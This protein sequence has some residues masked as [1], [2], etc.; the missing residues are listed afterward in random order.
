M[1]CAKWH[2]HHQPQEVF[3][4]SI[5]HK[6]L[7]P[8]FVYPCTERDTEP[9]NILSVPM[10]YK[11]SSQQGG[12]QSHLR[13]SPSWIGFHGSCSPFQPLSLFGSCSLLAELREGSCHCCPG[14]GV[15]G[16]VMVG[17]LTGVQGGGSECGRK[18]LSNT[19]T[20]E[21][22]VNL[23]TSSTVIVPSPAPLLWDSWHFRQY[24]Y[25]MGLCAVC[26]LLW[27]C[28][29]LCVCVCVCC[30]WPIDKWS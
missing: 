13:P 2:T 19:H 17:K 6:D 20:L 23:F 30:G 8:G 21:W 29:C 22:S 25:S 16:W 26:D 14:V 27:T 5:A 11:P 7:P 4:N 18:Q 9:P 12:H 28:V 24:S 1:I 3:Q 15:L 10:T